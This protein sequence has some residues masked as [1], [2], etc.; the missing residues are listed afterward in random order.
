[1]ADKKRVYW[2]ACAWLG[3]INGETEKMQAL[4]HVWESARL[5]HVE[6]WTSAF[7]IA[8]VYKVKCDGQWATGAADSDARIDALFDAD[9]VKV[10]QVDIEIARLARFLLRSNDK[11][12]KP[13]DGIHLATAV[14]WN[15]DQLHTYDGNDLLGLMGVKRADGGALEI[16]RP[17][18][19]DGDN[20]FTVADASQHG[21]A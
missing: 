10:V 11:L 4:Q 12:K 1:M 13:S 16:C 18:K 19:L 20:L 21:E 2:D 15:L 14:H 9:F 8:E 7:C 6:I 17:N 5:G 3:L